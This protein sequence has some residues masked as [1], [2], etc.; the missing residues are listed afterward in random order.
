MTEKERLAILC[1]IDSLFADIAELTLPPFFEKLAKC[2]VE[3]YLKKI[4]L[5]QDTAVGTRFRLSGHDGFFALGEVR[6]FEDGK[7]VKPI[8]QFV[9]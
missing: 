2:G 5:S 3:I 6:A 8:K 1:P 9:L 7:A 4:G